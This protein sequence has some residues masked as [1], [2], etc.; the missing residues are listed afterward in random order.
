MMPPDVGGHAGEHITCRE[1]AVSGQHLPPHGVGGV[2]AGVWMFDDA[3]GLPE[4]GEDLADLRPVT[5]GG[6]FG[7]KE[8]ATMSSS[9]AGSS[10]RILHCQSVRGPTS[11][12][13]SRNDVCLFEYIDLLPQVAV[14]LGARGQ[15]GY[16]STKFTDWRRFGSTAISRK[17]QRV[18]LA[19]PG[20]RSPAACPRP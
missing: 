18:G 4:S 14:A 13:I 5:P 7:G 8:T 1:A 12:I 11:W 20:R 2:I 19:R 16:S 10:R 6:G 17:G 15:R 9:D 3:E